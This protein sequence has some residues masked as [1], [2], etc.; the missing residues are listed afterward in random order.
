[1]AE[2][3]KY[4]SPS[5][6]K[7]RILCHGS[8][9][10]EEGV[11]EGPKPAADWGSFAHYIAEQVLKKKEHLIDFLGKKMFGQTCDHEM[12][13]CVQTYINDL[14]L[15]ELS[16][17]AQYEVKVSLAPRGYP[18]VFGTADCIDDQFFYSLTVADLKTGKGVSVSPEENEQLMTY[19]LMAMGDIYSYEKIR[20]AIS[21][22]RNKYGEHSLK[23]WECSPSFIEAWFENKLRPTIDAI[24]AGDDSL[25]PS[26][27]ACRFCK[28]KEKCPAF[29]QQSLALARADFAAVASLSEE[30]VQEIYPKLPMLSDWIKTVEAMA[31]DMAKA[32][33]LDGYKIV[34]GRKSRDWNAGVDIPNIL[35]E[36][37]VADPYEKK[38]L[39]PAKAE[40][41][42]A[43]KK[44]L[45]QYITTKEGQPVIAPVNDKRQALALAA[46]DFQNLD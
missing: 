11:T 30:M 27:E 25:N 5:S 3:S 33:R 22:P 23:V 29:N 13:V 43:N 2:H 34:A 19:A 12:L 32:G 15:L 28:G 39:S 26:E 31:F 8:A 20:I 44:L 6:I 18:E 17:D 10:M 7:R 16:N 4:F 24:N 21:Q 40:K 36:L 38:L 37:G 35:T 9:R 42:V 41:E 46:M 45:Q 1:M 14:E